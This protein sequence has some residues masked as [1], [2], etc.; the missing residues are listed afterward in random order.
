L[1][2]TIP[3][4]VVAVVADVL[5]E[6]YYSHS[7]LNTLFMEAGAPGTPPAGNCVQKCLSWLNHSN[8]DLDVD[9][10]EILGG[11]LL[12]LMETGRG[13]V[14]YGE[15]QPKEHQDR[16]R[17]VLARFG[18]AYHNGG[19]ILSGGDAPPVADLNDKLRRGDLQALDVEFK[20]ALSFLETDPPAAVTAACSLLESLFK[21][22]L[23][24]ECVPIPNKQNIKP[25]WSTV[26]N[27]LGLNPSNIA[28]D[29][30]L[31]ILSG[32]TSIVDGIG[33]LRTHA[34][35]AH[36]H[37][38]KTHILEPRQARLTVHAAHTLCLFVIETWDAYNKNDKKG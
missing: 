10:F 9:P 33:A 7:K 27:T 5:G 14:Y 37:G 18:L 11:V 30:I 32:L 20:R 28:G 26:Q 17:Q 29:D 36:G 22:V 4:P 3:N 23:E 34:G 31:R 12:Q 16:I 38:S 8:D 6:H 24:A 2:R 19:V 15:G 13:G 25:L 1:R 35:S 21:V